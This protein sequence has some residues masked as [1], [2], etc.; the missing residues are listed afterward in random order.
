MIIKDNN[1]IDVAVYGIVNAG[2]SS[3]LN[4]LAKREVAHAGPIGGT[5]TAVAS[6]AWREVMAEVG[7]FAVR[8]I[9]T[10]GLEEV[11]D[12]ARSDLAAEA[13]L[14]AD[15]IVFVAAED[16]TATAHAALVALREAGKPILVALNKMDLLE[17]DE[18]EQVLSSVRARLDTIVPAE[19]VIPV[20]A[21]PIVRERVLEP[22]GRVRIEVRRGEPRIALLEERLLAGIAASALDLK[23][24][25]TA[26]HT[27]EQ[28]LSDREADRAARRARAERAA[29]EIAGV[30]AIAMAVNPVPLIDLVSSSGSLLLMA[31]RVAEAYGETLSAE[32]AQGLARELMRGSRIVFWGSLTAVGIGG[33]LKLVPGLGQVAGGLA[34]AA[35]AGYILRVIGAALVDYYDQGHDWGDGGVV[36]ALDRVAERTDRVALTRGLVDLLKSR[37]GNRP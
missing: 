17:P 10:P 15:L 24:L 2:K 37:L 29:S 6:A 21:A 5:T 8:L 32:T 11:G 18:Q 30:Q 13:A 3:L 28:H 9:D 12:R 4:A 26:S 14:R 34:Q 22:D 20:S 36:A 23:E 25:S 19:D 7:P 16:L 33:A 35:A 27:V 31:R 1:C